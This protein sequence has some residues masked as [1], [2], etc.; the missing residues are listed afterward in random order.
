MTCVYL[1]NYDDDKKF[2]VSSKTVDYGNGDGYGNASFVKNTEI[3]EKESLNIF[4]NLVNKNENVNIV[5][6]GANVGLYSLYAKFLP[7]SQFYSFEPYKFT[8][9]ILNDNIKLN[10]ITNVKTYNFGIAD[11]KGKTILNVCLT[12]DGLHTMGDNPLRFSNITPMEVEIDT[13]DNIF[14]NNNIKVDFIKIDT[15]GYEYFILKGGEQ[16]I[17]TYKPIIQL[18]FN[19]TN[20]RQCNI[21]PRD[22]DN[23]IMELGYK[24]YNLT[25]EELI[26]VPNSYI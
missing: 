14:F 5:D 8:Y 18:E 16:T 15:E 11:K 26:I 10:D 3:W 1:F 22:L 17:K 13:L 20:M 21:N 2:L 9:D 6:I 23:Y 12:H 19:E 7:K 4:Y 24:V 25:S